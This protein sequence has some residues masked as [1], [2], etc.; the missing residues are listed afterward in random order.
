MKMRL[1]KDLLEPSAIRNLHRAMKTEDRR[2]SFDRCTIGAQDCKRQPVD[3]HAI[4]K[5]TLRLIARNSKV[6]ATDSKSTGNTYFISRTKTN[7]AAK[8]RPILDGQV[9]MPGTR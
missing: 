3:A 7:R 1:L 8:H 4:P 6:Y 2:H 5:C 9:G